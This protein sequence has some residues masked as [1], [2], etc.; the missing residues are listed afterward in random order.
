MGGAERRVLRTSLCMRYELSIV[1]LN[2]SDALIEEIRIN[3]R[4]FGPAREPPKR[5]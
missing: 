5:Y 1:F 2:F 4:A 3:V